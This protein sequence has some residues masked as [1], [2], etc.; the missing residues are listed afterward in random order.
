MC[1]N[2]N[3][4][5]II[6]ITNAQNVDTPRQIQAHTYQAYAYEAHTYTCKQV[7]VPA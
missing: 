5:R 6:P 3:I 2:I 4:T 7:I 1:I